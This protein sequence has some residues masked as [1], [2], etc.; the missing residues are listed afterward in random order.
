MR[1]IGIC[2][3][4]AACAL[5][6]CTVDT[7]GENI[8][9]PEGIGIMV[10]YFV[11]SGQVILGGSW[12]SVTYS[13][14]H[15]WSGA[16]RFDYA[17]YTFQGSIWV[18]A[19]G[20][21]FDDAWR[22]SDGVSWTNVSTAVSGA[23][24]ARPS[25]AATAST[26]YIVGAG[27]TVRRSSTGTGTWATA[28][29]NLPADLSNTRSAILIFNGKLWVLTSGGAVYSSADAGATPWQTVTTTGAFGTAGP[30][31][32]SLAVAVFDGR[33]WAAGGS[34]GTEIYSS[35]DGSAWAKTATLNI[36]PVRLPVLSGR[37][38]NIAPL[39]GHFTYNGTNWV[40]I[41]NPVAFTGCS[42]AAGPSFSQRL[43]KFGLTSGCRSLLTGTGSDGA[44]LSDGSLP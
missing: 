43:W 14:T 21:S 34:N 32:A 27:T 15:P 7:P 10:P 9:D 39:P 1:S 29:N 16:S 5:G 2:L 42:S 25:G 41:T 37:M 31:A 13:G 12:E 6:S 17:M 44:G 40:S 26:M 35:S 4:G 18:V 28:A 30:S 33:M 19:G 20:A 8:L 36:Q 24:I 11:R 23:A 3:V 22:S 38:W